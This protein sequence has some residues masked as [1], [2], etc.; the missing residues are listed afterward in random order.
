[1]FKPSSS[2]HALR[3]VIAGVVAFVVGLGMVATPASA[4]KKPLKV[5]FSASKLVS[6]GGTA[7]LKGKVTARQS[8]KS[9]RKAKVVIQR[10]SGK[11]WVK[12]ATVRTNKKGKFKHRVRNVQQVGTYRAVAKKKQFAKKTS[13]TRKATVRQSIS[14]ASTGAATITAGDVVTVTGTV[15]SGLRNKN[16]VLQ[17][18][19]SGTWINVREGN[20]G[21]DG[22]FSLS[23]AVYGAGSGRSLRVVAPGKKMNVAVSRSWNVDVYG[24][25]YLE[26]TKMTNWSNLG[27]IPRGRVVL[28]GT[29]Y[30]NSVRLENRNSAQSR[31]AEFTLA[32]ACTDLRSVA[33]VDDSSSSGATMRLEIFADEA[34]A[35]PAFVKRVGDTPAEINVPISGAFRLKLQSTWLSGGSGNS[36]YGDPQVRCLSQPNPR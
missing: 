27:S 23:G 13:K 9:V 21:S 24:W 15:S 18:S 10:K 30:P 8:K 26:D 1:M 14:L 17:R 11:R 35:L 33:G 3:L 12:V 16:L 4:A 28:Y 34:A 19:D 29:S 36:G 5:S 20:A 22:R 25:F 7:V 6:P 2:R 32:G 31:W